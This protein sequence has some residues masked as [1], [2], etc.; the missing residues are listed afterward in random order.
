[1][2]YHFNIN[3][4]GFVTTRLPL[5]CFLPGLTCAVCITAFVLVLSFILHNICTT[6]L[7]PHEGESET[8]RE[9]R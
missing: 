7:G 2:I 5:P 8:A 6:R 3:C 1:M 4:S 9:R